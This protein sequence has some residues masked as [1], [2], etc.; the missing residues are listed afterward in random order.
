MAQ[1][2]AYLFFN[3]RCEEAIGFYRRALGAELEMLMRNKEAPPG[4]MPPSMPPGSEDKVMHATLKI[5]DGVLMASDGMAAD[6]PQFRGFSLSLTYPTE[7]K[8]RQHFDA[9]AEGGHVD[10]PLGTTFWSSCFGMVTDR[11]GVQWMVGLDH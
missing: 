8:C 9:L 7:A 1:V 4:E 6:G 3:G 5:G 2:Q 10:M 11:F